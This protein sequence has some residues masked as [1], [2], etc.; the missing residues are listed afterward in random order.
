MPDTKIFRHKFKKK[1]M[2]ILSKTV[3]DKIRVLS[4]LHN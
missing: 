1:N 3:D 2:I 4:E